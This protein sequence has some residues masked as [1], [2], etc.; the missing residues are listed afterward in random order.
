MG[1]G[2]GGGVV[3][4]APFAFAKNRIVSTYILHEAIHTPYI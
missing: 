2:G 3:V 4:D 1:I